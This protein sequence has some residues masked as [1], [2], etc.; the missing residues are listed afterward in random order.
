MQKL[1]AAVLT[2]ATLTALPSAAATADEEAVTRT[3]NAFHAAVAAGDAAAALRLMADDALIAEAGLVETFAQYRDHHLA[4]DIEFERAVPLRWQP[5]R[6]AVHGDAAWVVSSHE[7]VGTF[8]GRAVNAVGAETV[9][10][11]R[12]AEGWRIRSIHASSRRR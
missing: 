7:A 3:V 11:T 6:V 9:V 8:K 2:L 1:L 10:L 12:T 4:E 5:P